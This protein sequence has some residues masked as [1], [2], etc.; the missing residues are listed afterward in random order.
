M[1]KKRALLVG[2][3]FSAAPIFYALKEYG[4]HVSVCGNDRSDPCHQ[5]AD[6]S[7]F[8]DYS[9]PEEL[10]SVIESGDFDFLV[11][12]CNDYSY[13]SCAKVT[14]R[15][16]FPGFDAFKTATTLHTKNLFRQVTK[17]LSI[18]SPRFAEL[19]S[20]Q[21]VSDLDLKFPLLMKPVDSF[22]GRG[23]TKVYSA[24][25][26][27]QAISEAKRYSRTGNVVVEEF[28]DASLHSHSA[29]LQDG[30]VKLDFF[31]DEFCTVY[32]YQVNCS[33]HPS[34]LSVSI[35]D[36]VRAA[37]NHVANTLELAN[38][39]IHT[40]F[41]VRGKDFWII[42]TMRRCPGDLYGMLVTHSTGV[43]YADLFIR[44][45]L[46][47]AI[48]DQAGYVN[49]LFYARHTVSDVEPQTFLSLSIDIP[50][51]LT[52]YV[53]LKNS[54]ELLKEAPFDKVGI[55]FAQFDD[56][57][58]LQE[59]TPTLAGRVKIKRLSVKAG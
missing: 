21:D 34:S 5:Y 41:M 2:S 22:S 18:P 47:M 39:L 31:V 43:N 29:F 36:G 32:P 19:S 54:G 20:E 42:E 59:I 48:D 16:S 23:M 33:N 35:R 27:S 8:I 10:L 50:S 4:L 13:M 25:E 12:T 17:A 9:K 58:Q 11:P 45:F 52:E 37:I 44:P 6:S 51:K 14:E 46:G 40:Q 7:Y 56:A 57:R 26:L 3:S 28:L 49:E 24:S 53:P 15:L 1:S 30:V 38:G 55:V